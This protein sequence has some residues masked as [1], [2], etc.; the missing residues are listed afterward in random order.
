MNCKTTVSQRCSIRFLLYPT[1]L[2]RHAILVTLTSNGQRYLCPTTS[3][4]LYTR[5]SYRSD[6]P[7]PYTHW[8]GRYR[9]T[10]RLWCPFKIVRSPPPLGPNRIIRDLAQH[11]SRYPSGYT[12]L[13]TDNGAKDY[14]FNS[15]VD[16]SFHQALALI[17]SV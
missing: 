17:E 5:S 2:A 8:G 1:R 13:R 10:S 14:Y 11:S 12:A 3:S 16:E 15:W 4:Y 9:H 7:Q 6:R